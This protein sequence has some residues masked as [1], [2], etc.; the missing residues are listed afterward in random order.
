MLA[1]GD[2]PS[3]YQQR[4]KEQVQKLRDANAG[5]YVIRVGVPANRPQLQRVA[6]RPNNVFNPRSYETLP[7]ERRPLLET[8]VFGGLSN[9]T[10]YCL[11]T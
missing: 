4:R 5:I 1:G 7:E 2:W 8:L 3:Q 10:I 6:S 9:N 11:Y